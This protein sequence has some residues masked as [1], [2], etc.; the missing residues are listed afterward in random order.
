MLADGS[1]E[2]DLAY[3]RSHLDGAPAML[4]LPTDHPRPA[5]QGFNGA[6]IPFELPGRL[7]SDL[8]AVAKTSGA[9]TYMALLAIFQVL[10]HRYSNQDDVV[11]GVPMANRGRA[12]IEPL[13][14]FFVN[15]LPVRTS[16]R[17]DPGFSAVLKRVRESCLGAYAH[18]AVPFEQ[19]VA[20]LKPPRDLSKPPVFQVS[21]SYQADPLPALTWPAWN[22][23][24][25]RCTS[26]GA[27]VRPGDAAFQRRG[28][29]ERLDRIRP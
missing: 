7:M 9:T 16:L 24:G 4:T 13:I 8:A 27:P 21:L 18:Q 6:S 12:E 17:G 10:L 29:A 14:G 28:R 23:G 2:S 11:V 19:L 26:A 25:S 3:W 1:L 22:C 20:D 5:V 15:T